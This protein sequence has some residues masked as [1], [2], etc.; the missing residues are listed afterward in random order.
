MH[1]FAR[2]QIAGIIADENRLTF[3]VH[4]H[5]RVFCLFAAPHGTSFRLYGPANQGRFSWAVDTFV[6]RGRVLRADEYSLSAGG[7]P[8]RVAEDG[9]VKL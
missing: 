6:R 5:S 3:A 1:G 8:G 4:T 2:L 7:R 9:V